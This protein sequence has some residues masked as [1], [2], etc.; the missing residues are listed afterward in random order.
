MSVSPP[1]NAAVPVTNNS[2]GLRIPSNAVPL[3]LLNVFLHTLH[4]YLPL[5]ESWITMFPC[6][7]LPLDAHASLGQNSREASIF[8]VLL[9]FVFFIHAVS[10]HGCPFSSSP[11]TFRHLLAGHPWSIFLKKTARLVIWWMCSILSDF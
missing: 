10:H 4:L 3:L 5:L 11:R 2:S 8:C 7:I 1:F 6:P 9:A